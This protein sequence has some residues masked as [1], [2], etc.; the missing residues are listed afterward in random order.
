VFAAK[1]DFSLPISNGS[2]RRTVLISTYSMKV[3]T[4]GRAGL[5]AAVLKV[6]SCLS[7]LPQQADDSQLSALSLAVCELRHCSGKAVWHS[8]S[9]EQAEDAW[10]HACALWVRE[11]YMHGKKTSQNF[12]YRC[13]NLTATQSCELCHVGAAFCPCRT[14]Q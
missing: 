3:T 1:L 11:A 7:K 5:Q 9:T 12:K 13:H 4:D 2:T 14:Q 10:G 6:T 8:S